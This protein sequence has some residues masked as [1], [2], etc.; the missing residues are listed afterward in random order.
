MARKLTPVKEADKPRRGVSAEPQDVL[1]A[2][3][4]VMQPLIELLLNSGIDY[5]HFASHLKPL[6]I[7]QA[8][9]ELARMQLTPTDSSL[10]VLSGVHRK[11]VKSWRENN[12]SNTKPRPISIS[13]QVFAAWVQHTSYRD[14]KKQP[15]PLNRTGHAP[16]FETLVRLITQDIHPFTVLQDLIRLDL[17]R[18]EIQRGKEVVVPYLAGFVPPAGS[19]EALQLMANHVADHA[20][21]A[22][23]NLLGEAPALEQSVYAAGITAQSAQRLGALSREWWEDMR[24]AL[25]QEAS[26]LYEQDKHL[27][28]ADQRVRIGSYFHAETLPL[29][30]Q[31]TSTS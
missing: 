9:R 22:V 10:S 28:Q 30:S 6:F 15:K 29:T 24:A 16:S 13:A 12:L 27:P 17:V 11:D 21:T 31:D 20:K 5:P 26:R 19:Q 23:A 3:S 7:E 8:R 2:L 4:E 18:V 1:A 14:R 25:I